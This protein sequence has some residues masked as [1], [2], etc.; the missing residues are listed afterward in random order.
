MPVWTLG[1]LC[2]SPEAIRPCSWHDACLDSGLAFA[3]V[4]RPSGLTCW[5]F[6]L[7]AGLCASLE[8]GSF[9]IPV[10]VL[11]DSGLV[12]VPVWRLAAL[13]MLVFVLSDSGL[14]S[15]PVWRLAAL[16]CLLLRCRTPGWSL[17]QSGGWQLCHACF[18]AVGLRAGLCASLEVGSD[19]GPQPRHVHT[20]TLKPY[21]ANRRTLNF[22]GFLI[23][24]L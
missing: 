17:C 3:P 16:S 9:I 13:V 14:V 23:R 6:G 1:W 12:S 24:S 8:A 11:S 4:W 20:N 10:F 5:L 22:L 18:C 15:V 21:L 7:R 19:W 2:A